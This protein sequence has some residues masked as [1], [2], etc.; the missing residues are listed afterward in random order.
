MGTI[1]AQALSGLRNGTTTT[2]RPLK[3]MYIGVSTISGNKSCNLYSLEAFLLRHSAENDTF[4]YG[5][6]AILISK[7]DAARKKGFTNGG[8]AKIDARLCENKVFVQARG[9]SA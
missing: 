3:G 6:F 9:T 2:K 8:D 1:A 5:A 7:N 4:F